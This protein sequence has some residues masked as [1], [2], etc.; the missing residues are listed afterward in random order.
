MPQKGHLQGFLAAEL[1]PIRIPAKLPQKGGSINNL[2]DW[3]IDLIRLL[4]N[5][6]ILF[7]FNKI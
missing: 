6:M 7:S 2:L 1:V 3:K 4:Q 5:L